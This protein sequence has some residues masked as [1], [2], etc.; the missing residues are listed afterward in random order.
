M[1]IPVIYDSNVSLLDDFS[2]HGDYWRQNS[3]CCSSE[4]KYPQI[5][6]NMITK[7]RKL[8]YPDI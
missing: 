7:E 1:T 3:R 2:L 6:V 8:E 4:G 5:S